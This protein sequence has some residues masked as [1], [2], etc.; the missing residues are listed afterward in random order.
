VTDSLT[1]S[2]NAPTD[3]SRSAKHDGSFAGKI[4]RFGKLRDRGG[5]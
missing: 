3:R 4:A 1:T 5:R 2:I